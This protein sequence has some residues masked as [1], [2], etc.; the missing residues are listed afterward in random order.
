[1]ISTSGKTILSELNPIQRSAVLKALTVNEYLLLKGLPGTGKTQTLTAII[2][3][4][5][6]MGKTVLITSHTNSAVDNLL[7]RLMRSDPAMKFMRLGSLNRM[8]AELHEFSESRLT[9]DCRTAEQMTEVYNSY[10]SKFKDFYSFPSYTRIHSR[11]FSA[12]RRRHL[13]GLGTCSADTKNI[14]CLLGRRI[15]TSHSKYGFAATL[16]SQEIYFGR[17][18]RSIAAHR[19]IVRSKVISVPFKFPLGLFQL[20]FFVAFLD[21]PDI[22]EP[23]KV[24]SPVWIVKQPLSH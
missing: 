2:R 12:N 10:V 17:R 6:M 18:S 5:V 23:T 1:M 24:C 21:L 22:W 15:N 14:R 13:L 8:R 3:L 16:L 7:I 9:A 4:Y 19:Q 20:V 11:Y